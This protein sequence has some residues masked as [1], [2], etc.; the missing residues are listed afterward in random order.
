MRSWLPC[1]GDNGQPQALSGVEAIRSHLD[2][3]MLLHISTGL[4]IHQPPSVVLPKEQ[5]H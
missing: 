1:N 2:R 5:H 3:F 4:K